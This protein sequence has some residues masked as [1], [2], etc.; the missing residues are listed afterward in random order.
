MLCSRCNKKEATFHYKTVSKG[1]VSELH[2]CSE[3]AREM[4]FGDKYTEL[5]SDGMNVNSILNQFFALSGKNLVRE[6]GV[7]CEACGMD[8]GKFNSTGLLGCDKCYDVFADAVENMLQ[9]TQGATSHNGKISGPDSEEIK[10]ENEISDLKSQL[11]KAILE[12]K[13]EDAA[14]LRDRIK[15][16]EK[17][18]ENNG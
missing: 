10:K 6:S 15:E 16:L 14:K 2:L 7:K 12:E 17:G 5:F 13:Y 8:Y 1:K 4:G 9:R 18:A 3:C 11:Q